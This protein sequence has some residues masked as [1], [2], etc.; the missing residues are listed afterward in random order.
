M[1][2][3]VPQLFGVVC[4]VAT[5]LAL[6]T[7]FFLVM[8]KKTGSEEAIAPF[9]S[10]EHEL[11]L[12]LG[13]IGSYVIPNAEC[14]LPIARSIQLIGPEKEQDFVAEINRN[15]FHLQNEYQTK[16]EAALG[17]CPIGPC[18]LFE[19]EYGKIQAT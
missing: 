3:Q 11:S 2:A 15:L 10:Y 1:I 9:N 5:A 4:S 12:V 13:R 18:L 8:Y 7:V 6:P 16:I 17:N 14:D 19:Y